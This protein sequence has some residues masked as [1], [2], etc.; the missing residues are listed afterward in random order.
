MSNLLMTHGTLDHDVHL[1]KQHLH[2]KIMYIV[3]HTTTCL[4][5]IMDKYIGP[6]DSQPNY[7]TTMKYILLLF[8]SF[9][10]FKRYAHWDQHN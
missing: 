2:K 3:E 7:H 6:V 5:G 8:P 10:H 4:H 9:S 1:D